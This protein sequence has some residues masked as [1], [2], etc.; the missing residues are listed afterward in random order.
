VMPQRPR[1]AGRPKRSSGPPLAARSSHARGPPA[2]S[3]RSTK[4]LDHSQ[5]ECTTKFTPTSQPRAHC[6]HLKGAPPYSTPKR[7]LSR[8]ATRDPRANPPHPRGGLAPRL[9]LARARAAETRSG[10]F[11]IFAT[12]RMCQF[13][14]REP[15]PPFPKLTR[16][17]A[18]RYACGAKRPG[19]HHLT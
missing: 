15:P 2:A 3:T 16:N 1:D 18:S 4:I 13:E 11:I 17:Y 7:R 5:G 14:P 12:P 10:S 9:K 6:D 19:D 8:S